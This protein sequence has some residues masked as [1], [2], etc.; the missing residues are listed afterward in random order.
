MKSMTMLRSSE[1]NCNLL[2]VLVLYI[3]GMLI[4]F[5]PFFSKNSINGFKIS[6]QLKTK[7]IKIP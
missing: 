6:N 3:I 7:M 4:T 1:I 2:I 5:I